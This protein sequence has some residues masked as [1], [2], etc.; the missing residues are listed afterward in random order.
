MENTAKYNEQHIPRFSQSSF[1]EI[2]AAESRSD[3]NLTAR[4]LLDKGDASSTTYVV[5][6]SD[7]Q[8]GASY[9]KAIYKG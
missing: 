6:M 9:F 3:G 8:L 1:L 2:S 7:E 5:L 4:M